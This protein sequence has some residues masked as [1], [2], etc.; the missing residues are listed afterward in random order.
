LTDEDFKLKLPTDSE[1]QQCLVMH[2]SIVSNHLG[3][4]ETLLS[5]LKGMYWLNFNLTFCFTC[6]KYSLKMIPAMVQ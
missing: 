1:T 6:I 5:Q 3:I 2:Q 4:T